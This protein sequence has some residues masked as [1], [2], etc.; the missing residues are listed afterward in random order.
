MTKGFGCHCIY[1]LISPFLLT[2]LYKYNWKLI[3]R[4]ICDSG[5]VTE[6]CPSHLL[7]VSLPGYLTLCLS[8]MKSMLWWVLERAAYPGHIVTLLYTD[9]W[10]HSHHS[11]HPTL[12]WLSPHSPDT[13]VWF[14]VRL[15]PAFIARHDHL[16]V[17]KV[18]IYNPSPRSEKISPMLIFPS[19]KYANDLISRVFSQSEETI[20][21]S[22]AIISQRGSICDNSASPCEHWARHNINNPPAITNRHN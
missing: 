13:R 8:P 17:N 11:A 19:S 10:S 20:S 5:D 12:W 4:N 6:C 2:E 3:P 14:I 16:E 9:H 1:L 22:L 18:R 21:A 15:I 7:L